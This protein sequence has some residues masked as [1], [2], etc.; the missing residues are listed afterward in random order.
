[1][2]ICVEM[3]LPIGLP[4][5]AVQRQNH[6]FA[7]SR[8]AIGGYKYFQGLQ[9]LPAVGLGLRTT[10]QYINHIFV[11]ERVPESV[12]RGRFV[13]CALNVFVDGATICEFPV[14]DL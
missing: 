8:R 6:P 14:L 5:L 2:M 12:N 7:V 4:I 1:M 13:A 3:G 10:T 9:A 11:V